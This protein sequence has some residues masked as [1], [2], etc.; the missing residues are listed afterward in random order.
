MESAASPSAARSFARPLLS[1]CQMQRALNLGDSFLQI[2]LEQPPGARIRPTQYGR[3]KT[4][5]VSI[6]STAAACRSCASTRV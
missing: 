6:A 5:S 3:S 1:L 4:A 2:L